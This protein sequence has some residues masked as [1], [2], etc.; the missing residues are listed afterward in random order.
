MNGVQITPTDV[1]LLIAF[2]A[3]LDAALIGGTILLRR[4]MQPEEEVKR[5]TWIEKLHD[6]LQTIHS[7]TY[8]GFPERFAR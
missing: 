6:D 8:S 7:D 4:R 5:T 3:V 2:F 1:V